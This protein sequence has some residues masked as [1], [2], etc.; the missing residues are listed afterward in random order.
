MAAMVHRFPAVG[1]VRFEVDM[2]AGKV[3]V[4]AEL[5]DDVEVEVAPAGGSRAHRQA[6]TEATVKSSNGNVT[7][8]V[9]AEIRTRVFRVPPKIAVTARIPA[10]SRVTVTSATAEVSTRGHLS[11][12]EVNTVSAR[13]DV[14]VEPGT[15]VYTDMSKI[16]GRVNVDPEIVRVQHRSDATQIV[17]VNAVRGRV[18]IVSG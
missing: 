9:A 15:A 1:P 11:K 3:T 8:K 6:A 14:L 12:V 7:V 10:G 2:A 17:E 16:L 5:R 4:V 18:N 13:V